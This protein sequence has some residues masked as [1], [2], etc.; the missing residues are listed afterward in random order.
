MAY[1]PNMI[2]TSYCQKFPF[3]DFNLC[4]SKKYFHEPRNS[5]ITKGTMKRRT[6]D[7]FPIVVSK[8]DL[9]NLALSSSSTFT[10]NLMNLRTNGRQNNI[11]CAR[12]N[13]ALKVAEKTPRT[14]LLM[15]ID[16]NTG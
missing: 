13:E 9:A 14:S 5:E 4:R 12:P 7:R 1:H 15:K 11:D 2:G 10:K 6:M 16:F 3:W 8:S